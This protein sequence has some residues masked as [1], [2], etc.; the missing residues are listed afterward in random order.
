MAEYPPG[1]PES[2][3]NHKVG[4]VPGIVGRLK[5]LWRRQRLTS[6]FLI[7]STVVF[8][9]GMA[10]VGA[11]TSDR[12]ESDVTHHTAAATALYFESFVAPVIQDLATGDTLP[13]EKRY[14]LSKLVSDTPISQR[15]VSFKIWRQGGVIA[16]A[17]QSELIGKT[18]PPSTK[19]RLAWSGQIAA[20]VS[21]LDDEENR[22]ERAGG[23]P[24]LEVYVPIRADNS[25]RIIAV[26]EFYERADQLERDIFNAQMQGWAIIAVIAAS[27]VFALFGIVGGASRT[28]DRQK[29]ELQKRI[30]ELQNLLSQNRD[31]R[32]RIERSSQ[33]ALE[34][35]EQHLRRLGAELHDG[36]AQLLGLALLRLDTLERS[37][38]SAKGNGAEARTQSN[39]D[40][41]TIRTAL[42]DAL[43]EIRNISVGLSLPAL[44]QLSMG[45]TLQA[46]VRDHVRRSNTTVDTDISADGI[47]AVHAAKT[48]AFRFVQEALG[49]ATRHAGAG[50]EKKVHAY[51]ENGYVIIEVSDSGKGF[52]PAR[53]MSGERLGLV[54]LRERVESLG[55]EFAIHSSPGGGTTLTAKLPLNSGGDSVAHG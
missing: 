14:L 24:L 48:A 31:L 5:H 19:L 16:Y 40:A 8:T 45:A 51:E 39:T 25:G 49:N 22:L 7:A 26:A 32:M 15:V 34:V 27:A 2:R 23:I 20:E 50:A 53:P 17:T 55:G 44:D 1:E 30:T 52:D 10:I 43:G 47:A 3:P 36:P 35:N 9:S 28:I 46:A 21:R 12:I 11:W 38:A 33:R 29:L 13:V 42:R 18:F 54:G 6:Q 41:S 37:A 4:F